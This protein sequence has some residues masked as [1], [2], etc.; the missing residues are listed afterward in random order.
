MLGETA[1]P[2]YTW[3]K[4][5]RPKLEALTEQLGLTA[6]QAVDALARCQLVQT[7]SG[8]VE[9]VP[10]QQHF[11]D[12]VLEGRSTLR[13]LLIDKPGVAMT[14]LRSSPATMQKT[15]A[16]LQD[17]LGWSKEVLA[18]RVVSEHVLLQSSR[19]ALHAS[20]QSI[21]NTFGASATDT[22][23]IAEKA[24]RLLTFTPTAIEQAAEAVIEVMG[25]KEAAW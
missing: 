4:H 9:H 25:S 15:A 18:S 24:P 7:R 10:Q 19:D 16:Y 14:L 23:Q 11:L 8:W 1:L 22:G 20:V 13:Q 12:E 21:C 3:E 17:K 2:G 5:N 6:D